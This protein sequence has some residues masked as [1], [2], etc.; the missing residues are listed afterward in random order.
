MPLHK[1]FIHSLYKIWWEIPLPGPEAEEH[2]SIFNMWEEQK[3]GSKMST[4]SSTDFSEFTHISESIP[5]TS[6]QCK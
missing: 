3:D 2:K 4:D 5:S 1:I 6:E